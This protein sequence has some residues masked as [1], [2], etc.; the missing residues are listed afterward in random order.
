MAEDLLRPTLDPGRIHLLAPPV[1]EA[2]AA[3]EVIDRPAAAVKELIENSQDAGATR[4]VVEIEGGGTELIRVGDDGHGMA[5]GELA[6]AFQRHA[7]SKLT[8]IDNLRSLR[9]FG[10]RG[11]A[12]AS[13]AAVSRVTAISRAEGTHRA[14][15]IKLAAGEVRGPVAT[16]A[17]DGTVVAARD[18]FFNMPARRAFLRAPRTEAAACVR[19]AQEAALGRPDIGFEVRSGGR[20]VLRTPGRSS[21]T[22]VVR[23]VF[24]AEAAQ[25]VLAVESPG[26]E[27][28]VTG[29][30]GAPGVARLTRQAM[31]IMVN[32]RRVQHRGLSAAVEGAY[33]GLLPTGRYPLAV[34]NVTCDPALVDVNV[35][36]TKREVRLQNEGR[37]FEA[38]QRACWTALQ[39]GAPPSLAALGAPRAPAPG[40]NLEARAEAL[41]GLGSAGLWPLSSEPL[42]SSPAV[43]PRLSE[44]AQ[45]R[46]LGQAHNRYLVVETGSG[47]ALLDQHAAH[48]K[49]LYARYL[50]RLGS[51][52]ALALPAQ[53][54]LA[55]VL[56][57]MPPALLDALEDAQGAL[58][59]LGFEVEAFGVGTIRCS[60]LPIGLPISAL[61]PTLVDIL[62]SWGERGSTEAG[63]RHRVAASLA[64]HS[65][66]RFGDPMDKS[67]VA[68]LLQDLAATEGGI[69]CPHGRPTVLL[70]SERE[71]LAAFNRR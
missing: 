37:F 49:V 8:S 59:R 45:W 54:L 70:I 22:A 7:T 43:D 41:P 46:Y 9:T 52:P 68:A 34:L 31:V 11:E 65:A 42:N 51:D 33:R 36:P 38:V 14:Y 50:A 57:E 32:G 29:V 19:V 61:E 60:A 18:L 1:A 58:A 3:G 35:H 2:I 25:A 17:P 10:F 6:A 66:V 12:L 39:A 28:G 53:G 21:L 48:E 62:S 55:P 4:I 71:L 23:A 67:E 30:L 40:A 27:V 13:I 64:C 16:A 15:E 26:G 5:A 63:R 47:L 56:A 24:G 69:T 44:A 20:V